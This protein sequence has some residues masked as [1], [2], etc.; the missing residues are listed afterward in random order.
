MKKLSYIVLVLLLSLVTAYGFNLASMAGG[1]VYAIIDAFTDTNGTRLGKTTIED[2]TGFNETDGPG[3]VTVASNVITLTNGDR[4][5]DYYVTKDEGAGTIGDFTHWVDV[6]VTALTNSGNSA[7]FF[8]GVAEVSDDFKDMGAPLDAIFAGACHVTATAYKIKLFG[9]DNGVLNILNGSSNIDV[10]TES[11][12]S[13]SRSGT[14]LTVEIYSTAA[15]RAAGSSGDVDTVTDTAV[16]TAFRYVYGLGSYNQGGTN[17]DISGTVSN[18]V[19]YSKT[20]HIPT[21][22]P[23]LAKPWISATGTIQTNAAV[24]TETLGAE[25]AAGNLVIGAIYQITATEVDTFFVGCAID[26]Y[27]QAEATT[28]L[29]ALNKVKLVTQST[30]QAVSDFGFS[31]GRWK[32]TFGT[33]AAGESAGVIILSDNSNNFV[34]AQYQEATGKL[35]ITKSVAGTFTTLIDETITYN[36]GD[37]LWLVFDRTEQE[38]TAFF[39]GGIVGDPAALTDASIIDNSFH[40]IIAL[41]DSAIDAIDFK[42]TGYDAPLTTSGNDII[43]ANPGVVTVTGHPLSNGD[44]VYFSGLTQM[45]E[46]NGGYDL[47]ANAGAND[48]EIRDTSGFVSAETTGGEVV[49]KVR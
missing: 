18:L 46:L 41:G 1:G 33:L 12:L 7:M 34:R 5:E 49:R 6:N 40:G 48:F 43:K 3:K 10:N 19:L 20:A 11:F 32:I 35:L 44:L 9:V 47:V 42:E 15:L 27:F 36:D 2:F 28:G 39:D 24:M 21:G 8:W 37:I 29:D 17:L 31:G 45:T 26:D 38:I 22:S 13:I 4:D 25:L 30:V 23:E 14:T 16:G